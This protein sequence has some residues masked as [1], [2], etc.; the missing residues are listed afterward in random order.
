M[1]A[2]FTADGDARTGAPLLTLKGYPGV[3]SAVGFS[4]GGWRLLTACHRVGGM[5][6]VWD[7]RPINRAFLRD[8]TRR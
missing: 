6:R 3:L 2:E 5:A 1:T 7:A 4:A 8:P